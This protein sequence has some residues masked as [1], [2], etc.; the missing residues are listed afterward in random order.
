MLTVTPELPRTKII[1]PTRFLSTKNIYLS[2]QGKNK[3]SRLHVCRN[4]NDLRK[5]SYYAALANSH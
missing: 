3:I 2:I 1:L 5:T 4:D